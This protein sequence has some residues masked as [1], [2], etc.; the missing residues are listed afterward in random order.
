MTRKTALL[1]LLALMVTTLLGPV[2]RIEAKDDGPDATLETFNVAPDNLWEHVSMKAVDGLE[3]K[4]DVRPGFFSVAFLN[5]RAMRAVL[6]A[7][8]ALYPVGGITPDNMRVYREAGAAGFGLGSALY[9]PGTPVETVKARA[10][11]FCSAWQRLVSA[12]A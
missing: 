2:T 8:T 10:L 7:A 9:A 4:F 5:E 3:P 11:A 1:A 12:A 6:P